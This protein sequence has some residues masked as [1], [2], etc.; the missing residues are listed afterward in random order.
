MNDATIAL[1]AATNRLKRRQTSSYFLA[2]IGIGLIAGVLGPT[3]PGLAENT[4]SRLNQISVV[5]TT[6]ALG[7]MFGSYFSG[8][9]YDRFPAHPFI[10]GL[11]LLAAAMLAITP[12]VS[13]L[14]LLAMALFIVGFGGGAIDV[15]GNTLLIWVHRQEV[16]SRMNALHFFFG[17]GSLIAPLIVAQSI[18]AS[19]G[20]VW[21][22]WLIALLLIPPGIFLLRTPSPANTL[23][24]SESE[25]KDTRWLLVILITLMFFLFVGAELAFGG[26]IYT[27]AI[28]TGLGNV[29]TAGYINSLFWGALTLGRL[30]SIP[31]PDRVR[32]RTLLFV[33][34]IGLVISLLLL[35]F[36]SH[37]PGVIWIATAGMGLSMANVF[38]TLMLLAE[39]HLDITGRITSWF[40]VGASL[41]GMA[42]PWLIGQNFESYGPQATI[43]W[44]L[45]T[46]LI[47]VFVLAAFLWAV[48]SKPK[49]ANNLR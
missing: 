47:T 25:T 2:F 8:R 11:I 37:T 21:A 6:Q 40:L 19:E 28:S 44:I 38:P 41:G 4:A 33:D 32:A 18:S 9:L 5:F 22:Y 20:I 24:A 39:H 45:G 35:L 15:G 17:V 10:G 46:V 7:W 29:T 30:L 31:L 23:A 43:L 36:A 12:L 1:T 13:S 16:G 48:R 34:I 14:T 27:Y 3:L 42:V 26:W 49:T